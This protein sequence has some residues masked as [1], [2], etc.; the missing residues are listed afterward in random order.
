[1]QFTSDE[2]LVQLGYECG[3]E[4]LFSMQTVK[5]RDVQSRSTNKLSIALLAALSL[6]LLGC[7]LFPESSFDLAPES[8]LPKWF[9]LPPGLSRSDVTVR[10]NYYLKRT[11]F[12]LRALKKNEKL[13]EVTGTSSEPLKVKNPRPELAPGYPSYEVVTVNGITE[14][15]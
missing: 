10:M 6:L 15:I 4:G 12:I 9:T 14:I 11:T 3:Y 8:R 13:A 2:L 1:M 5:R 7:D